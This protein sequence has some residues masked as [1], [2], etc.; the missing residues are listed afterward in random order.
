MIMF[1]LEEVPA[2]PISSLIE[3]RF[4]YLMNLSL[5]NNLIETI[6]LL[7]RMWLPSL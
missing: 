5:Q 6:E 2:F 3:I 7:S 4:P 1:I